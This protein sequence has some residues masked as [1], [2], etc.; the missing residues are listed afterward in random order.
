MSKLSNGLDE[1]G[2][3]WLSEEEETHA[4]GVSGRC[5]ICDGLSEDLVLC[6][7]CNSWACEECRGPEENICINC[8]MADESLE[9]NELEIAREDQERLEQRIVDTWSETYKRDM[10]EEKRET[11]R[12]RGFE[13]ITPEKLEISKGVSRIPQVRV[14]ES[15]AEKINKYN[16]YDTKCKAGKYNSAYRRVL[17]ARG[18]QSC[19]VDKDGN[20]NEKSLVIIEDGVRDFDMGRQMDNQFIDRLRKKLCDVNTRFLLKRF[21]EFTILSPDIEEI[22]SDTQSFFETL[23]AKS[24][25]GLSSRRDR[26]GV[27]ATKIMNFLFPELF[28]MSDR[29]VMEGLRKTGAI[30]ATKYWSIMM[31]CHRELKEWQETR[32]DLKSLMELDQRPTTLPRIFD[33]CAF[34][35]GKLKL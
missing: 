25:Y 30:H 12:H 17:N 5:D 14:F 27:G 8:Q 21:T 11:Q 32:G 22:K 15:A 7:I 18:D 26:F 23:S 3:W 20:V 19:L 10:K 16:S 9:D 29:W 13:E 6:E 24:D 31:V 2:W 33:K 35:M 28:V 4:Q 1:G 34:V